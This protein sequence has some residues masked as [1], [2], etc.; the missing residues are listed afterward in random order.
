MVIKKDWAKL[1]GWH[2]LFCVYLDVC[3]GLI[4]EAYQMGSCN[5]RKTYTSEPEALYCLRRSSMQLQTNEV[6]SRAHEMGT[7]RG[8]GAEPLPGSKGSALG[9]RRAAGGIPPA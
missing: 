4:A 5:R 1:V 9:P 3:D 2:S 8:A 7:M 6:N